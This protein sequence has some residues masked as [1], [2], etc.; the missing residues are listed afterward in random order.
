MK[1]R[2]QIVLLMVGL[3][4]VFLP[5]C[6]SDPAEDA[7]ASKAQID[8]GLEGQPAINPDDSVPMGAGKGSGKTGS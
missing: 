6:A 8:K 1:N 5:G 7:G 3:I 2:L 4:A